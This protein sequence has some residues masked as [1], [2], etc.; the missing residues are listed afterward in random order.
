M[1][2]LDFEI[3]ELACLVCGKRGEDVDKTIDDGSINGL[4]DEKYGVNFETYLSIVQDLLP[5]TP[6]VQ[7][8][9]DKRN[10]HAFVFDNCMIV[11]LDAE[12]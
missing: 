2:R 9:I 7:T 5:F 11:R 8:A 3:E 10:Y 4:L 1:S 12:Q 6:I